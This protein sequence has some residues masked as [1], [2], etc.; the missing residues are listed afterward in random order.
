[1]TDAER[2][3]TV[4]EYILSNAEFKQ[5]DANR[6]RTDDVVYKA[7]DV[8]LE[9]PNNVNNARRYNKAKREHAKAINVWVGVI[10]KLKK[11]Y[12]TNND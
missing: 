10:E 3:M 7:R 8:Y 4:E 9:H 5:A 6:L 11:E 2:E 1:M 12:K